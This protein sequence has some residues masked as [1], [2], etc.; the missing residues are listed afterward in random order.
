MGGGAW[1]RQG[2]EG[3]GWTKF[4]KRRGVGNIGDL[5]KIG[6]WDP[7]ANNEHEN[8]ETFHSK[9]SSLFCTTP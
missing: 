5:H 3:W 1:R 6:G 8:S 9:F 4:E 7:S 2:R